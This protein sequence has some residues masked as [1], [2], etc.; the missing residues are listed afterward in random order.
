MESDQDKYVEKLPKTIDI[1]QHLRL[2]LKKRQKICDC[3]NVLDLY[4][5]PC[6]CSVCRKCTFE[7]HKGH[8]LINRNPLEITPDQLEKSFNETENLIKNSEFQS[9][10]Y[11]LKNNLKKI[12]EEFSEKLIEKVNRMKQMRLDEIDHMADGLKNAQE[13]VEN[14]KKALKDFYDK[15]HKFFNLSKGENKDDYNTSF[16]LSYD[17]ANIAYVKE[18]QAK[19]IFQV[20]KEDAKNYQISLE[21]FGKEAN[22]EVEKILFGQT[23]GTGPSLESKVNQ[24]LEISA[25]IKKDIEINDEEYNPIQHFR[26]SIDK[27]KQEDYRDISERL[28]KYLE[29]IDELKGKVVTSCSTNK[30]LRSIET[31]L[32]L[33][34]HT[35]QKGA[36][37]LFSQRAEKNGQTTRRKNSVEK[38]KSA[39]L[40]NKT[41]ENKPTE[42]K[43]PENKSAKTTIS[44]SKKAQTERGKDKD[45]DKS[46][47]SQESLNTSTNRKTSVEKTRRPYKLAFSPDDVVLNAE[48]IKKLFSYLTMEL[49]GKYFKMET[50]ELQ[51]SHADLMIRVD[52][53]E[54]TDYARI[55]EGTNTLVIYETAG[56]KLNKKKLDLV[57]NPIGYTTFPVGCRCLLLNK[58]VYISGGKDEKGEY[59]NVLIYDSEREKVKR[60]MDLNEPRAFHTMVYN[61]VFESIMVFGGE[62]CN[63]VEVFDPLSNRWLMLPS[64]NFPR[65]DVYFHFDRPKGLIFTIFGR[66]GNILDGKY[67]D[68][69]EVLDLAE[70][71]NGWC[72]V[73]YYNKAEVSMKKY[74]NLF[75]LSNCLLLAYGGETARRRKKVGVIINLA[76]FEI[77]K[78]DHDV[79]EMLYLAAKRNQKLNSI[80][81]NMTFDESKTLAA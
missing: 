53:E 2:N 80:M 65:A 5:I 54:E 75:P 57:I 77:S 32:K 35:N 23:M 63:S 24:T 60:V 50:K 66:E 42:N 20:L 7:D 81:G 79:K 11:E 18:K 51:S 33:Y 4:C 12:V 44:A 64:M 61:D 73:E 40:E 38:D 69:I 46:K 10:N 26:N 45:K 29:L 30:S 55:I 52:E 47:I 76:K 43:P 48:C 22:D 15:T 34:E 58:K 6:K 68:I 14:I 72:K 19:D 67:S 31:E 16:L 62:N 36:D 70:F 1:F 37:S 74:I 27:L 49:Y 78:I 59:P 21:L 8:I 3:D 28:T 41:P 13:N 39:T 25:E 9:D 17:I 71:K 56:N